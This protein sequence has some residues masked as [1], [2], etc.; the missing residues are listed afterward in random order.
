MTDAA[1]DATRPAAVATAPGRVRIWDL[2]TRLFHWSL[3]ALVTASI[4]AIKLDSLD[5]HM[6][7]GYAI[8]ALL[9]FRLLWGFAGSR[10]ALFSTFVRGPRAVADY[11]RGRWQAAGGHNPLGALSVMALI[12]LLTLQA[13]GGLFA[14]DG[15]FTEGPLAKLVSGSTSEFISTWHRRAE[16]AIYALVALHVAAVVF[17]T[18]FKSEPLLGAM[19]HGDRDLPVPPA[20]DD[21]ALRLRALLL[22]ALCAGL[23]WLLA[24]L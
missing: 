24:T 18:V 5:W 19:I 3:A 23:V 9:L 2:P 12:A 20:Q 13:A 7:F 17:Y 4:I 11:L 16:Y 21:L 6:R 10:Y 1:M 14:N 15:S 8:L 22:L